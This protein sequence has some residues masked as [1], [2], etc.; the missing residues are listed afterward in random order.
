MAQGIHVR[1]NRLQL[2]RCERCAAFRR[3]R[4]RVLLGLGHSIRNSVDY[5]LVASVAVE[6]LVVG[7]VRGER[8]TLRVRPVTRLACAPSS[9]SVKDAVAE[10]DLLWSNRS[11]RGST[12]SGRRGCGRIRRD[13]GHRRASGSRRS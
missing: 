6:P 7:E 9:F 3:H 11:T 10:C 8:G 5:K 2:I 4:S 12:R 13:A 1:G